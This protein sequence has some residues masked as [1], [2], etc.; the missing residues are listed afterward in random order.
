MSFYYYCLDVID[1]LY[2]MMNERSGVRSP[3]ISE[4]IYKIIM[5]NAEVKNIFIIKYVGNINIYSMKFCPRK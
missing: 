2:N 5:A 3:M 1:D 4:N